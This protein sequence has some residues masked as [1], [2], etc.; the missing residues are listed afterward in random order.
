[1]TTNSAPTGPQ[2]KCPTCGT[3]KLWSS[4]N[5]WRPF[6]S[7]RCQIIDFGA[8]ANEEHSIAVDPELDDF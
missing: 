2:V 8:W 3:E 5:P 1:M 4:D 6:C 7:E